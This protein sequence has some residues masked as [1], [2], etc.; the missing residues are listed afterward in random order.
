MG[1]LKK[2][3]DATL[4]RLEVSGY[5]LAM[6][7][8]EREVQQRFLAHV[9]E[10]LRSS[11]VAQSGSDVG[12]ASEVASDVK[13]G[14]KPEGDEEGGEEEGADDAGSEGDDEDVDQLAG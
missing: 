4:R 3:R 2:S 12:D 13:S 11:V 7:L 14:G 8:Q 1:G 5:E 10:M 6:I 9:E